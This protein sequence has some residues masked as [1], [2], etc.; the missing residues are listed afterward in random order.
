MKNI[1]II[2]GGWEGHYPEEV[3]ELY[4]EKLLQYGCSSVITPNLED[5]LEYDKLA[6]LI[7]HVTDGS[8]MNYEIVDKIKELVEQGT[9]L[10]GMHNGILAAFR[11]F[12]AFIALVGGVF[13]EH[14]GGDKITY[15][16][17]NDD[18]KIFKNITNF[19]HTSEQYYLL[20]DPAVDVLMYT[21]VSSDNLGLLANGH[22]KIKMP[23][24]IHRK[25]GAGEILACSLGHT[26]D[27]L[28]SLPLAQILDD[29]FNYYLGAK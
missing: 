2:H 4:A 12:P 15:D 21:Y 28:N 26:P 9:I 29:V 11:D 3:S 23:V 1:L 13:V 16:V 19:T 17:Y 25:Y 6:M 27:E 18:S 20:V 7:I 24:T 8:G 5:I 10:F 22:E 14:Y